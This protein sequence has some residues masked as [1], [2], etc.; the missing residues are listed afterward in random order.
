[1]VATIVADR[2][3]LAAAEQNGLAF[4]GGPSVRQWAKMALGS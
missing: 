3:R 2:D 1:V 4:L